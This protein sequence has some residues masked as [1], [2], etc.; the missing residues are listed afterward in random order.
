MTMAEPLPADWT[1][2]SEVLLDTYQRLLG[3][4]L[5]ARSG[6][7][8]EDAR[9]LYLAPFAVLA[10]GTEADPILDYANAI[11]L[12]LWEMTPEQLRATPSRL[13]AEPV[14][15]EARERVLAQMAQR[16]FITGYEGVRISRT[17]RRFRILNV[18]IWN[19]VDSA[20][21]P[22]GQAATFTRWTD[23]PAAGP[24]PG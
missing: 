15:R 5:I 3:Q 18:T 22:A 10:H 13:T 14:V 23:V 11:A 24:G 8:A 16:G 2:R 21:R 6:N 4:D 19:L 12:G 20:G 7:A 17:G 9:R 1:Q